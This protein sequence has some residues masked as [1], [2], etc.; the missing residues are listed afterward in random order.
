MDG[1]SFQGFDVVFKDA[2]DPLVEKEARTISK[3]IQHSGGQKIRQG[4]G[5]PKAEVMNE[6]FVLMERLC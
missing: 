6:I 4:V 1:L 3:L 2:F 5:G